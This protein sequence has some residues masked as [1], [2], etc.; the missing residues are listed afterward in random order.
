MFKH[1]NI[2]YILNNN[3]YLHLIIKLYK[4][5][6]NDMSCRTIVEHVYGIFILIINSCENTIVMFNNSPTSH[7]V[8]NNMSTTSMYSSNKLHIIVLKQ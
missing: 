1:I 5:Q 2:T 7:I 4:Q 8:N 3:I 6:A